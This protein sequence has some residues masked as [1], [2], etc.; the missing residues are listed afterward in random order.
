M[1]IQAKRD[2][3][4]PFI[5][6]RARYNILNITPT[7]IH[8][9][10]ATGVALDGNRPRTATLDADEIEPVISSGRAE[11]GSVADGLTEGGF[12]RILGNYGR[13]YIIEDALLP[14][15][16]VFKIVDV[17]KTLIRTVSSP[18]FPMS[19]AAGEYVQITGGTTGGLFG[20]RVRLEG[21]RIV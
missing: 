10:M 8:L 18:V 9:K 20:L 17:D 21:T 1:P 3:N 16:T 15:T 6:P 2:G 7:W 13:P 11:F 14:G 19:L 5:G 12:F 4:V